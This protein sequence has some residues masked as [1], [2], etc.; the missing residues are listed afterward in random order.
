M[1]DRIR[2]RPFRS[3]AGAIA[4]AFFAVA[5]AGCANAPGPGAQNAAAPAS[6]ASTPPAAPGAEAPAAP[7][8]LSSWVDK[9]GWTAQRDMIAAAHPLAAQA[10]QAMLKAGGT[11][12]DA[13]IAAQMVLMLV[14]PQASGIG[15][16][17][18]LLHA[19]GKTIEAYDGRETAPAAATDRLFLDAN[20]KPLPRAALGARTVGAP[21][22]LRM[23]ELAHRAH[24]KLPWRRLFQ[25]AIRLAEQGFPLGPR[26]AA[27]LANEPSLARDPAARA[28]FYDR[29]GAPKP[30]GTT[31]KNPQLAATLRLV[32]AHG[33]NAFYTGAIAR[34]IVATVRQAPNPGVLSMQDLAQ[35]RAKTREPLCADYRKWTVC[36][37][38]PPSAGGLVV[39]QILG[40]LEAQPDWRQIGAQKPVRNAVGV[41][42]T[43]FAAHLFSEAGRLAYADRAQYV[44]DPDFVAPPGGSWKRLVE[45]RYVAERARLIGDAS[46]GEASAGSPSGLPPAT[47]ADRGAEP[48][49][50]SQITVVD[51]Y[52]NAVSMAS[53]LDE[54]FGSRLMVRGF[55]LNSQLLDFSP[56]SAEHGKPVA[57]RVQPGKRARSTLAPELVFEKGSSRLMMALGSAGGASTANDVAKT[58]VGMIDW[59]MTMQQA[60]ALP[61]FGSR[62]GPTELEQGRVSDALAG[63]LKA[64]GHDVR[65][66]ELG[67][68]LQ[69][70]QRI[71]VEGQS[72]WFG[73]SDPRRDGIVAGD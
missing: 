24:G 9:P 57:N 72:V 54:R 35:Y 34:D 17:A 33:A 18:F 27:A 2:P 21:G 8:E 37:M 10:G 60:I 51:R 16:G 19:N 20:G 3:R 31:L 58:L 59:G 44:A 73:G 36:G 68:S 40:L 64:R 52:G 4:A 23:L 65:V 32:A 71:N 30:A 41:E 53:T 46:A 66:V 56:A 61:N 43:P 22:A 55:L 67:S 63:A 42:P 26:L 48:P 25:P 11:A 14:E 7:A 49:S 47:A 69:G 1:T 38:P 39:A 6:A 62:N 13:A 29:N 70:I 5:A 28:Y 12:V 50:G 45:R 15:G